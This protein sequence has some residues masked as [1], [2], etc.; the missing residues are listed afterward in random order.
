MDVVLNEPKPSFYPAYM[1][2]GQTLMSGRPQLAGWKRYPVRSQAASQDTNVNTKG[3]TNDNIGSKLF[4]LLA[5]AT[6][7]GNI[8][9]HNLHPEELGGLLWALPGARTPNSGTAWAWAPFGFGSL[10]VEVINLNLRHNADASQDLNQCAIQEPTGTADAIKKLM[11]PFEQAME[12][13]LKNNWANSE[14]IKELLAM[15]N[16]ALGDRAAPQLR[17]MPLAN[18]R[19][20]KGG[21]GNQVQTLQRFTAIR[22]FPALMSSTP[23]NAL[24]N[25]PALAGSSLAIRLHLSI[26]KNP[27]LPLSA[28]NLRRW[29]LWFLLHAAI[30][31]PLHR[32]LSSEKQISAGIQVVL[33]PA[34]ADHPLAL[35]KGQSVEVD[36]LIA[37]TKDLHPA[38]VLRFLQNHLGPHN[39][40]HLTGS[41]LLPQPKAPLLRSASDHPATISEVALEFATPLPFRR[42]T[43]SRTQLSPTILGQML[44]SRS[45][46]VWGVAA[47]EVFQS[48]WNT[49]PISH[50]LCGYWRFVDIPRGSA[51]QNRGI[52]T[53]ERR[54][55]LS[56]SSPSDP[57]LH[58]QHHSGCLGRLYARQVSPE[59]HGVA[60]ST[61]PWHLHSGA[62]VSVW[63]HFTATHEPSPWFDPQLSDV[64]ALV[65]VA[66][67]T[68]RSYD[69]PPSHATHLRQPS[70][71]APPQTEPEMALLLAQELA[72]GTMAARAYRGLLHT[73]S[74]RTYSPGRA[75]L[76]A[77]FWWCTSAWAACSHQ[78]STPAFHPTHWA[79]A[80]AFPAST[81][82]SAYASSCEKATDGVV[83]A[84]VEDSSPAQGSTSA[85][86]QHSTA[87]FPMQTAPC[88]HSWREPCARQAA[89]RPR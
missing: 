57:A 64:Q 48:I 30:G 17:Y 26:T 6:F 25:H 67:A 42:E 54:T 44:A 14:Q 82:P 74:E 69:V 37:S 7:E 56:N 51:S 63:G 88:E 73:Q 75:P 9:L 16:P 49:Q 53:V 43:G 45:R 12:V 83:E 78:C 32:H 5:G 2:D 28:G 77:R 22:R 61:R 86:K 11:I 81:P 38:S 62:G 79:T 8:T 71:P 3:K 34:F 1:K 10:K 27:V 55:R 20:V 65:N 31:K 33:N 76:F 19:D 89:Q 46:Q 66:E 40:L 87:S 39:P 72:R 47:G 60:A 36:L 29:G 52:N 41:T 85:L 58:L 21:R 18:F 59:P 50:L 23:A 84:D 13:N 80:K 35:I 15:A 68:S 70:H 4:P 24:P